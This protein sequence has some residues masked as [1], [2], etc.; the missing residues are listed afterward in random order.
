MNK[1][2]AAIGAATLVAFAGCLN[3]N[4]VKKHPEMKG[5]VP[6]ADGVETAQAAQP[7]GAAAAQPKPVADLPGARRQPEIKPVQPSPDG[8]VVIDA[9]PVPPPPPAGAA[10]GKLP[11][12]PPPHAGAELPPPTQPAT[13]DYIVQRDDTLSKISKRFNIKIS[14]IRAVNPQLKGDT[15]RVGQKLKL[16]GKV[17]VG[18]Q[19][20]PAGA[21]AAPAQRKAPAAFKPYAGKTAEYT[22]QNGDTLGGIAHK[23]G[24]S[25]RQLRE[26]NGGLAGDK[27]RI[28]AKLTVPA[29]PV[30]KVSNQA[31]A[32]DKKP[33]PAKDAKK[34]AESADGAKAK[35]ADKKPEA[36]KANEAAP[37][38][39]PA[40]APEQPAEPAVAEPAQAPAPE[41]TD[42]I[43]YTVKE[44]E[45]ITGIAILFEVERSEIRELNNLPPEAVLT[46]G[47]KIKI[48]KHK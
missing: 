29:A 8:P 40:A 9:T 25:T 34:K 22:I 7:A 10:G 1:I 23:Y 47:M 16:P 32:K 5:V 33:A 2:G 28:G 41:Q 43:V 14:S 21:F 17:E 39:A 4:Y 38:P 46:P 20:V 30:E 27:I 3:P 19:K 12:P 24:I 13:T 48:P 15:I 37:E 6:G 42:Y 44:N 45:D 31:A 11:P 18:E 26:L 36:A 35:P